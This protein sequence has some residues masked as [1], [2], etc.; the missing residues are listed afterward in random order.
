STCFFGVGAE[1]YHIFVAEVLGGFDWWAHLGNLD[2]A[3]R[4]C[5]MHGPS[6]EFARAKAAVETIVALGR[7]GLSF[8]TRG[9]ATRD[10]AFARSQLC[11]FCGSGN[12]GETIDWRRVLADIECKHRLVGWSDGAEVC[13]G[14]LYD[15]D[16]GLVVCSDEAR[17]SKT[18]I[19][20]NA[21]GAN[22]S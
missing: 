20:S 16:R 6:Y 22:R 5:A 15:R 17:L 7:A 2:K 12:D 1:N 14:G 10:S 21:F 3:T 9:K 8:G 13:R 18:S 4:A 11:E 19:E